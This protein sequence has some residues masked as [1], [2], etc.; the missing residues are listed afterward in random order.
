MGPIVY[1]RSLVFLD[2]GGYLASVLKN[3]KYSGQVTDQSDQYVQKQLKTTTSTK[4]RL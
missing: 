3:S 4:Y 2:E 1:T